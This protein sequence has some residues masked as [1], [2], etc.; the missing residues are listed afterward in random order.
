MRILLA[1]TETSIGNREDIVQE[2]QRLGKKLTKLTLK[3]ADTDEV[4]KALESADAIKNNEELRV[5]KT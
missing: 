1:L 2:K 3:V 5:Q 4:E